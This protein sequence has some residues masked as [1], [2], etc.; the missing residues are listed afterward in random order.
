MSTDV[1]TLDFKDLDQ[2]K[3]ALASGTIPEKVQQRSAAVTYF[4]SGQ[5]RVDCNENW[6]K[7]TIKSLESLGVTFRYDQNST[8][9]DAKLTEGQLTEGQKDREIDR[10]TTV[11]CWPQIIPLLP[12]SYSSEPANNEAILFY[13]DAEDLSE[14]VREILRLGNDRQSYYFLSNTDKHGTKVLLK[15]ISPP[16]YSLLRAI[17]Q[18]PF[19]SG[20]TVTAFREQIPHLWVQWGYQ[21]PYGESLEIAKNQMILLSAPSAWYPDWYPIDKPVFED[22]YQILALHIAAQETPTHVQDP[23]KIDVPLRLI[24]ANANDQAQ[25][26]LITG[27]EAETTFDHFVRDCQEQILDKFNFVLF[28]NKENISEILL[29]YRQSQ[30]RTPELIFPDMI[31]YRIYSKISNLFVPCNQRI[32]PQLRRDFLRSLLVQDE[33]KIVFLLPLEDGNFIPRSVSEKAFRPLRDWIHYVVQKDADSITPWLSSFQFEFDEFI[34]KDKSTKENRTDN[35]KKSKSGNSNR[36]SSRDSSVLNDLDD[37]VPDQDPKKTK[38]AGIRKKKQSNENFTP[39]KHEINDEANARLQLDKLEREFMEL[40]GQLDAPGRINL[41]EPIGSLYAVL[42][43]RESAAICFINALWHHRDIPKDLLLRWCRS[44]SP[45]EGD[46]EGDKERDNITAAEVDEILK[47]DNPTTRQLRCLVIYVMLCYLDRTR[48]A[49]VRERLTALMEQIQKNE[50]LIP[51]RIVWFF[52][53]YLSKFNKDPLLLVRSRDRL[54]YQ[55]MEEGLNVSLDLPIF[56]RFNF[57]DNTRSQSRLSSLFEYLRTTEVEVIQWITQKEKSLDPD[58]FLSHHIDIGLAKLTFAYAFAKLQDHHTAKAHLSEITKLW[59]DSNQVN[60]IDS[61][62]VTDFKEF[63]FQLYQNRIEK[64]L[65]NESGNSPIDQTVLELETLLS[66]NVKYSCNRLRAISLIIEPMDRFDPYRSIRSGTESKILPLL[67][68]ITELPN[69]KGE[70]LYNQIIHLKKKIDQESNIFQESWFLSYALPLSV[71]LSDL[72]VKGKNKVLEGKLTYLLL[73]QSINLI[74]KLNYYVDPSTIDSIALLI[75]RSI[76]VAGHLNRSDL[77]EKMIHILFN[78]LEKFPIAKAIQLINQM[79]STCVRIL[80]KFGMIDLLDTIL[81]YFHDI[82]F[83][84]KPSSPSITPA[85]R[86]E[87]REKAKRDKENLESNSDRLLEVLRKKHALIWYDFVTALL[88]LASGWSYL[89]Q[90]NKADPYIEEATKLIFD[91]DSLRKS[92]KYPE[93]TKLC[94]VYLQALTKSGKQSHQEMIKSVFAHL[95]NLYRPFTE[96]RFYGRNY[97]MVIE[98]AILSLVSDESVQ[99]VATLRWR[100]EDE[101]LYRK[102]LHYDVQLAVESAE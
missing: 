48:Y 49:E 12:H 4:K 18:L 27:A 19:P 66:D 13:L 81:T 62:E 10:M 55:L 82:L 11:I 24:A 36:E 43:N 32:Q 5:I 72:E 17:D 69:L 53:Y 29:L 99:G 64:T 25:M 95:P 65:K 58:R 47:T 93:Y 92:N 59:F 26:W 100:D 52:W 90:A 98:A 85:N 40:P 94:C 21:Y 102:R 46:K 89:G 22:I 101:F 57:N 35:Q 83:D 97:V 86:E 14:F 45:Q 71:R 68:K 76:L 44:E 33:S 73:D 96:S 8:N 67:S 28:K 51:I 42:K 78:M 63:V 70:S 34:C 30:D 54:L 88:H 39:Q 50:K 80:Q 41:W 23:E 31:P 56:L 91:T 15:V 9:L 77:I 75:D 2:L 7:K 37:L 38:I 87:R 20:G 1:S 74:T 61:K 16:Y 79:A 84:R 60:E 3:F 6:D